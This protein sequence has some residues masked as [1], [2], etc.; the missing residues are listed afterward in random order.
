MRA[1]SDQIHL[2]YTMHC[3]IRGLVSTRQFGPTGSVKHTPLDK[4]Q[5]H[6]GATVT[7]PSVMPLQKTTSISGQIYMYVTWKFCCIVPSDYYNNQIKNL[8]TVSIEEKPPQ[9]N[10]YNSTRNSWGSHQQQPQVTPPLGFPQMM[11][12]PNA[13]M[14][15][16]MIPQATMASMGQA[17]LGS[18][19]GMFLDVVMSYNCSMFDVRHSAAGPQALHPNHPTSNPAAPPTVDTDDIIYPDVSDWAIYCDMHPKRSRAQ[20]GALCSKLTEQGFFNLDQ[21]TSNQIEQRDLSFG[22]EIGIG[23]AALIIRYADEDV[24]RVRAGTFNMDAA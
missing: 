17:G 4:G 7:Q 1:A 19:G 23:L 24:A 2:Q 20:V 15:P 16:W 21:L 22:L 9:I 3:V 10:L 14:N 12:Y 13:F 6:A 8:T 5:F 11:G 18:I